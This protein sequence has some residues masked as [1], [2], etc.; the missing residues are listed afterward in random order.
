MYLYNPLTYQLVSRVVACTYLTR[1]EV[2]VF[3]MR[4]YNRNNFSR[5]YE[6]DFDQSKKLWYYIPVYGLFV[7]P[8]FVFPTISTCK[9]AIRKLYDPDTAYPS[10]C[11]TGWKIRLYKKS[12]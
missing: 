10:R 1:T 8:E 6:I 9:A 5:T 7:T 4:E 11:E 12:E 3:V 2:P